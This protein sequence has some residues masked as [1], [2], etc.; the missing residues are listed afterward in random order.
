MEDRIAW[1]EKEIERQAKLI[2]LYYSGVE[3]LKQE[4]ERLRAMILTK[5][6]CETINLW[7][8]FARASHRQT[9]EPSNH[10]A[11]HDA[12]AGKINKQAALQPEADNAE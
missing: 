9:G 3:R 1:L 11:M 2:L 8:R 12:V 7:A 5:P 6:E 4:I 10:R